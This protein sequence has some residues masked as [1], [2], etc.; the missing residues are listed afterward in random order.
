[1]L[2]TDKTYKAVVFD[3]DG[4]LMDST[5]HIV[6]SIKLACADMGMPQPSDEQASW[7]IGMSLQA[8]LYKLV[9]DL[10]AD[11]VDAFIAR[12][13]HHFMYL[14]HEINLFQ[15]QLQLLH[16][17]NQKGIVL[18]VAT[19]KSRR[20]LDLFLDRLSLRNMFQ[21]TKTVDEARGK[22][23]PDMLEQIIYELDLN[24]VNVLMVGDTSHDVLMAQNAGIDSLAV[25]YGAHSKD[26][27]IAS[28]PSMIL[29]TVPQMQSWL[30]QHT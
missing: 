24:P 7:V 18:A 5:G 15:G 28:Q 23:D 26:D 20:G 12:Y 21:S 11:N 6:K 9:P 27:L 25:A 14:Q 13:R 3:W 30:L 16:D 22:P 19:G 2:A 29:D 17:L 8:A 4:T 1:M 10:R